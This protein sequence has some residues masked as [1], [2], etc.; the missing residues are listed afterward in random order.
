MNSWA[1]DLGVF[2][3][4][5]TQQCVVLDNGFLSSVGPVAH[6]EVPSIYPIQAL[7]SLTVHHAPHSDRPV[8]IS[9][10]LQQAL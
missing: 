5:L 6:Q 2:L 9:S 7:R 3:Q 4:Q 10:S 1:K 8:I